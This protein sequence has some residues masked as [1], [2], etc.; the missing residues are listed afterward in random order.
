MGLLSSLFGGSKSS[1]SSSNK[2]YDFLQ[3]SLGGTVG[4]GTNFF[5]RLGDELSGGFDAF[6]KKAGFDFQL[7]QGLRGI[8]GGAAAGGLL[9]SGGTGQAFVDYGNKLGSTMYGNYLDRLK[10]LSGTG[11]QAAGILAGAGQTSSS[12][13]KTQNGILTS[14]FS[15]RRL[16]QDVRRIGTADNGLPIYAY[17]YTNDPKTTHIGFMADEVE[18]VNPDAVSEFMGFKTVDYGKAVL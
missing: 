10:D 8:T 12:S 1:S 4:S 16:K 17:A 6:K 5:N 13:D 11:L 7:G 9:R 15:E 14:L 18:Q 3:N 2:A